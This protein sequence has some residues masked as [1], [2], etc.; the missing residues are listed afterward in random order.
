MDRLLI[1]LIQLL[2]KWNLKGNQLVEKH[3]TTL[4]VVPSMPH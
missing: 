1:I 2:N 3:P 4:N